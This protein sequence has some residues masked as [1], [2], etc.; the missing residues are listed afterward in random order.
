MSYSHLGAAPPPE[1]VDPQPSAPGL[2]PDVAPTLIHEM[3][4]PVAR[5]R[6]WVAVPTYDM[7]EYVKAQLLTAIAGFVVGIG[8]GATLGNVLR[9]R[10]VVKTVTKVVRNRRTSRRRRRR[11]TRR[12]ARK[13]TSRKQKKKPATHVGDPWAPAYSLAPMAIGDRFAGWRADL[14]DTRGGRKA[15]SDVHM[16]WKDAVADLEDRVGTKLEP[17]SYVHADPHRYFE[18]PGIKGYRR[19]LRNNTKKKR[20]RTS[21]RTSS[22]RRKRGRPAGGSVTEVL[23]VTMAGMPIMVT[24]DRS[25]VR[26]HGRDC[27]WVHDL[28]TS[29]RAVPR[30]G[31][32][33]RS[34]G[35]LAGAVKHTIRKSRAA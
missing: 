7:R 5:R 35:T 32:E 34:F 25:K 30:G 33:A 26:A 29:F 21:R 18:L 17:W 14:F 9:G 23:S 27:G 15:S 2:P 3:F 16:K 10:D 22:R 6:G 24:V 1:V 20:R 31:G 12:N 13:R 19:K 28:G 11:R 4:T 8:I